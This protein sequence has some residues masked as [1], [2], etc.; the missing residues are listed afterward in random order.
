MRVASRGILALACAVAGV[1][2]AMGQSVDC[3]PVGRTIVFCY[4][5]GTW[6]AMDDNQPATIASY[7]GM[8]DVYAQFFV[9][10][11]GSAVGQTLEDV[12][13]ALL[14]GIA[15]GE[16][17]TEV[18]VIETAET[19]FW[20]EPARTIVLAPAFGTESAMIT[21]TLVL[22]EN[23]TMR[24]V[25]ATRAESYSPALRRMHRFFLDEIRLVNPD[26]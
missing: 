10:A 8:D 12:Q 23:E 11:G 4:P 22:R 17:G 24:L 16:A 25:T 13:A 19:E 15:D 26:G 9:D 5:P 20:G 7:A 2:P 6:R 1:G 18:P 21:A 14:A 3:D